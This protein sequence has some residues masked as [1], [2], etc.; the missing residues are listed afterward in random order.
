[1]KAIL[2]LFFPTIL[3]TF[4]GNAQQQEG[5]TC[6]FTCMHHIDPRKTVDDYIRDFEL[7]TGTEQ[8]IYQYGAN[9]TFLQ[10]AGYIGSELDTLGLITTSM[11]KAIDSGYAVIAIIKPAE[12]WLYHVIIVYQYEPI[13]PGN[14]LINRLVYYDPKTGI[15]TN[16]IPIWDFMEQ[17]RFCVAVKKRRLL[18]RTDFE[19]LH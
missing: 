1:M 7:F 4:K 14:P 3:L 9:G 19:Q 8:D 16:R 15:N 17:Q 12:G 11:R 18:T 5:E 2:P 13:G 6:L 10:L